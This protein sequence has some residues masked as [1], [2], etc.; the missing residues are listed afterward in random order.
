MMMMEMDVRMYAIMHLY[1]LDIEHHHRLKAQ[2]DH[3]GS[4][5]FELSLMGC[6]FFISGRGGQE[7][8]RRVC[9]C[10]CFYT[11]NTNKNSFLCS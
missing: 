8:E 11:I 7:S 5:I 10:F 3:H 1:F 6:F 4:I 9:Y 2:Y